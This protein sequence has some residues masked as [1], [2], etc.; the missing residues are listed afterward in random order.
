MDRGRTSRTHALCDE[1]QQITHQ[2]RPR[3]PRR[4]FFYVKTANTKT[5]YKHTTR[6]KAA[7]KPTRAATEAH[8]KTNTARAAPERRP[9]PPTARFFI[10]FNYFQRPHKMQE[11]FHPRSLFCRKTFIK[12]FCGSCDKAPAFLLYICTECKPGTPE[13]HRA[14]AKAAPGKGHRTGQPERRPERTTT[15]TDTNAG[16]N[17]TGR[18]RRRDGQISP[19]W[20]ASRRT[21]AEFAVTHAGRVYPPLPAEGEKYS[22]RTCRLP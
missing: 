3:Y 13:R 14:T 22:G 2:S 4:R 15:A 6:K 18:P 5:P 21:K 1:L 11:I 12:F 20:T 16:N 19:T 10:I 8:T 7:Q 9:D 17:R